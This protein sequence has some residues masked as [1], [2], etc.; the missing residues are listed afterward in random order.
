MFNTL[1]GYISEI[2]NKINTLRTKGKNK[3]A[4]GGNMNELEAVYHNEF[5]FGY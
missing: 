4:L 5:L 1:G 3:L 2:N